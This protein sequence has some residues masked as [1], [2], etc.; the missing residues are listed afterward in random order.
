MEIATCC[1]HVVRLVMQVLHRLW[2]ALR[3]RPAAVT[4]LTGT[5]VDFVRSAPDL[6]PEKARLR[7]PGRGVAPERQ[8]TSTHVSRPRPAGTARGPPPRLAPGRADHP[9]PYPPGL[10]SRRRPLVLEAVVVPLDAVGTSPTG[11]A[12]FCS[13]S[14]SSLG[15][16]GQVRRHHDRSSPLVAGRARRPARPRVGSQRMEA[17]AWDVRC[18]AQLP[19]TTA[20]ASPHARRLP[21]LSPGCF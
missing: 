21:V 18:P 12:S 7:P 4:H 5:A 17:S 16:F 2:T 15:N 10:A 9:A 3:I 19:T 6:L 1:R 8:A 11:G 14:T 20:L 13:P